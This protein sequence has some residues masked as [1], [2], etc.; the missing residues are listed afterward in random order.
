V[1]TVPG[2]T[3]LAL[4]HPHRPKHSEIPSVSRDGTPPILAEVAAGFQLLWG[5]T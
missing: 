2:R 5:R 4:V 1:R 3:R